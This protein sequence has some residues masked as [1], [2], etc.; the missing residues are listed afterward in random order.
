MVRLFCRLTLSI[1]AAL[2]LPLVARGQSADIPRAV[3]VDP[4]TDPAHPANTLSIEIESHG[5]MMNGVIYRPAGS[6]P[7]PLVILAHGLPGNEQ[8][9]DLAQAMRRAG[10]AVL[11]FHY[12][13]AFGSEG[14]F[15]IDGALQDMDAVIARAHAS[16]VVVQWNID[17]KRI[18]LMGH[19]MGG[20][21]A[22]HASDGAPDRLG[23]ALLAPWDPSTLAGLLRPKPLAERNAMAVARWGDVS[24]GRLTGISAEQISADIV[25]HG[26]RWRL[27][28]TAS[29]LMGKPLLI[30]TATHDQPQSKAIALGAALQA[31]GVK[32]VTTELD[33]NHCFDDHRIA[34]EI[35]VLRWLA[36]LPGAPVG[37]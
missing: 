13:G 7:F 10:W 15:S 5:E 28:D 21:A 36:T 37:N 34:L 11:T 16:D 2:T 20:L 9:L 23:T 30:V 3:G 26:E 31:K 24:H 18:V 17:P 8:N 25:D 29:G 33:S 14:K 4:P 22:A 12:R 1:L 35:V 32:P 6:G 27:A 19:S